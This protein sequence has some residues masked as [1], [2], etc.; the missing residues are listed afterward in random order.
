MDKINLLQQ[1]EKQLQST[2]SYLRKKLS[3]KVADGAPH[4]ISAVL[5]SDAVKLMVDKEALVEKILSTGSSRSTRRGTNQVWVGGGGPH[6]DPTDNIFPTSFT[7]C[8]VAINLDGLDMLF[9]EAVET[10][11]LVPCSDQEEEEE[12]FYANL[13]DENMD[14][15]DEDKY[16]ER[17]DRMGH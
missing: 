11:N 9:K 17:L 14:G 7:G 1:W 13:L 8:I 4:V 2:T 15:F 3:V 5:S 16:L 10:S 12:E 6:G